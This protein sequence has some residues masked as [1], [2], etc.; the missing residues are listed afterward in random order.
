[1]GTSEIAEAAVQPA[2]VRWLFAGYM[3]DESTLELSRDGRLLPIE[4]KPL[5]V[6]LFMLQ[7]SG[8]VVTKEELLAAVWPG[9]ILS[10]TALAKC[11]SRLREVLGDQN[12]TL[13]KTAHGYGY[14]FAGSP[15]TELIAREAP[16]LLAEL[17]PGDH[18]P[19]RPLWTLVERIGSG[20]GGD[21]WKV[22]HDKTGE[23]RVFKFARDPARLVGLKREIT[24]YRLIK[25]TLEDE[26]PVVTLLDWN[27]AE[28]PYFIES[29]LAD[30]GSLADWWKAVGGAAAV[31]ME[32]RIE[33]IARIADGLAAIHSIGVL[34]KDLKPSN[35]LLELDSAGKAAR[36]LLGDLGNGALSD[37]RRMEAMG[38]TRMG[39]TRT[40]VS[41]A[42]TSGT[43]MYL[44]PEVLMGQPPT[45]QADIYALGVML[46]QLVLGDLSQPLISG[47]QR[48]VTDDVLRDDIAQ[49]VDGN[50]VARLSVAGDLSRR[51][52]Q[53]DKRRRELEDHR[54]AEAKAEMALRA[55]EKVRARRFGLSVAAGSLAIGLVVSTAMYVD[56]RKASKTALSE[57]ARANAVSEFLTLDLF[58]LIND[59]GT[60][61]K[62]I[63][64]KQLLDKA[65]SEAQRRFQSEPLTGAAVYHMLGQAFYRLDFPAESDSNYQ[66]ALELDWK[67]PAPPYAAM[68]RALSQLTTVAFDLGQLRERLPDYRAQAHRLEQYLPVG[69]P[70]MI[71]LTIELARAD[72]FLGR[73]A[74]STA[75]L[76][77]LIDSFVSASPVAPRLVLLSKSLLAS[78]L[79]KL[80]SYAQAETMLGEARAEL[81]VGDSMSPAYDSYLD[82]LL[83]D[84]LV[85]QGRYVEA[86]KLLLSARSI[87]D[88]W[89]NDLGS[90]PAIVRL[91]MADLRCEQGRYLEAAS[92][93]ST[94]ISELEVS[95]R[96]R[97][98][99]DNQ[100]GPYYSS[101][102]IALA[103][104]GRV[105]QAMPLLKQALALSAKFNGSEHPET[106]RIR[107]DIVDALLLQQAT[108]PAATILD[109]LKVA[110]LPVIDSIPPLNLQ[111]L[112]ALGWLQRQQAESQQ[113][114]P[115]LM[116]ARDL[117][118]R[119][120]GPAHPKTVRIIRFMR[121]LA[122]DPFINA[123][124][125][126]SE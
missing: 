122:P 82:T 19:L 44:A 88:Q 91:R 113:A 26:A 12:Q 13:I 73:Y 114:G 20:G 45:I 84:V 120:Y 101:L 94:V 126:D 105:D 37:P 124:G 15:R 118:I 35:V 28:A 77:E 47:W 93:L 55:L 74:E 33:L 8:E 11:I 92:I 41:A 52:R 3:L 100:L 70:D 66:R 30:G 32:E 27:L 53:L 38:I 116:Q 9:R 50:P 87:A 111:Y 21:T 98:E 115:T 123:S 86:E 7:H 43:P 34:H 76:R 58:S 64:V 48:Y 4:R 80:G 117:A 40:L 71:A 119:L 90:A 97:G 51:V 14:R 18:P 99:N 75:A 67:S 108:K 103:A 107:L 61:L 17:K 109:A 125:V 5:E 29:R 16:P 69:S 104:T 25:N 121:G 6:L 57:A 81:G 31:P 39:F 56:A 62:N 78:E 79:T 1:M 95:A 49:S 106:L 23:I 112:L 110:F 65:A 63:T 72:G 68:A 36:V 102:G 10:D 89:A 22:R 54:L 83:G 96:S 24:L 59:G 2:A 42:S 60:P 46:Y 85:G